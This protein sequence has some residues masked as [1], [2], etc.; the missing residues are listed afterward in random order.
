MFPAPGR[1]RKRYSSPA[2]F[3][4]FLTLRP[5]RS[6]CVPAPLLGCIVHQIDPEF[7][8]IP[9]TDAAAGDSGWCGQATAA[10]VRTKR[11]VARSNSV[12]TGA[13]PPALESR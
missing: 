10:S 4:P 12:R 3:L 5:V 7:N 6:S 8:Q 2:V 13:G 9:G 1:G 11:P